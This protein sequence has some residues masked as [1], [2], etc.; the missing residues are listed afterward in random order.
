MSLLPGWAPKLLMPKEC[1]LPVPP[2]GHELPHQA[3]L[4]RP[5]PLVWPRLPLG[6]RCVC[7][8]GE[9]FSGGIWGPS[10]GEVGEPSPSR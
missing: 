7:R 9:R 6:P 8:G 1:G 5:H 10:A 2:Y 4:R 3:A